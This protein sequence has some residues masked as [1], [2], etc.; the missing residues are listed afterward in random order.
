MQSALTKLQ[1]N[2]VL[3]HENYT[4]FSCFLDRHKYHGAKE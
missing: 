2:L 3:L 4:G 1:L